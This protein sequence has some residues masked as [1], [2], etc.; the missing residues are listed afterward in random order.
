MNMEDIPKDADGMS[1]I[2]LREHGSNLSKPMEIDFFVAVPNPEIGALL[3]PLIEPLGFKCSLEQD[4][5]TSD[6]TLYCFILVIPAYATIIDIQKRL[7]DISNPYGAKSDGWGTFG[8]ASLAGELF[9]A[10]S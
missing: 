8:N 1:L 2:N 3:K 10:D 4:E 6:W 5:E 7:N 9:K